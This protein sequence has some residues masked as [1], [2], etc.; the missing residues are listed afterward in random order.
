MAAQEALEVR[1]AAVLMRSLRA[2]GFSTADRPSPAAHA[3]AVS[4]RR[5]PCPQRLSI[6]RA[7]FWFR[8][9]SSCYSG[10]TKPRKEVCR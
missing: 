8:E 3:P 6:A 2:E 5:R 10:A 1:R 9:A 7:D 4:A